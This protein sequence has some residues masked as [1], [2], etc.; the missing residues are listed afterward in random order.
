MFSRI[1]ACLMGN[2]PKRIKWRTE[3]ESFIKLYCYKVGWHGLLFKESFFMKRSL[4]LKDI[5][6]KKHFL[7]LIPRIETS[8]ERNTA[9]VLLD[10]LSLA[11]ITNRQR[12]C[13]AR[14]RRNNI[15][16]PTLKKADKEDSIKYRDVNLLKISLKHTTKA[17]KY[18][19]NT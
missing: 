13:N 6:E 10:P 12:Y 14:Y 19:L 1:V 7:F 16:I 4:E 8:C 3:E 2:L 5:S 11:I 18:W 15:T 17:L 9:S